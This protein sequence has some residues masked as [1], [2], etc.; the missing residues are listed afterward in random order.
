MSGLQVSLSPGQR[1]WRRFRRNRL[2]LISLRILLFMIALTL[3]APLVSNEHP[4]LARYQGKLYV[5]II[6]N[7]PETEFGGNFRTAT[8][9]LDP[10]IARNFEKPG[11]WM[12]FPPNRYSGDTINFTTKAAHPAPPSGR[13]WLGTDDRGRDV[14]RKSTRLNSSHRL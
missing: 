5:P 14:D 2:G 13:N 1:A 8:D 4:L 6:S 11:N 7:P 3:V 12:V 9:W 10:L